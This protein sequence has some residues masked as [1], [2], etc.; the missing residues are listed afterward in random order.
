MSELIFFNG[1]N[2]ATGGYGLAPMT[3]EKLA[4]LI[5]ATPAPD[6]QA[7]LKRRSDEHAAERI[8][9]A[10]G[11]DSDAL[12]PPVDLSAFRPG[13]GGDYYLM[14]NAFAPYKRDFLAEYQKGK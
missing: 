6:N 3:G 5:T 14:V 9:A 7:D 12:Y 13:A 1:I 2:G 4:D 10:Y 8:K 11:R